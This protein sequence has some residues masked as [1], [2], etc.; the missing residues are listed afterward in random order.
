MF[1]PKPIGG[2]KR[3]FYERCIQIHLRAGPI[4][5]EYSYGFLSELMEDALAVSDTH[6]Y[7][8]YISPPVNICG[9]VRSRYGDVLDIFINCGWPFDQKYVFLGNLFD[10]GK[11]SLETLVLLVCCKMCYPENFVILRGYYENVLV[12]TDRNFIGELRV[13]FSESNKWKSLNSTIKNYLE[14][15]PICSVL[16]RKILCVNGMV[17]S[18]VK[19]ELNVVTVRNGNSFET[20]NSRIEILF[21]DVDTP[22]PV[23]PTK[24]EEESK[25]LKDL[26]KSLDMSMIINSNFVVKNGYE[27]SL[28]NQLLTLTSGT[29]LTRVSNNRGIVMMMDRVN[30]VTFKLIHG[31]DAEERDDLISQP[32]RV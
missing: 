3:E 28:N 15:L 19:N 17:T 20:H 26:L 10:G 11:F 18:N 27:F 24:I 16:N 29:K 22:G 8:E 23:S 14:R 30:K 31:L 1:E 32:L 13:K 5:H 9:D 6:T 7:V 21:P 25:I 4:E 2:S 12:K